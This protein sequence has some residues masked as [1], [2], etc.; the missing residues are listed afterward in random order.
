[1][2]SVAGSRGPAVAP[3]ALAV[4]PLAGDDVSLGDGELGRWQRRNATATASHVVGQLRAAG[5]LDNLR[6]IADGT[7]AAYR[8]R[9]PFLDTDVYKTLEGLAYILA[10][11]D[12]APELRSFFE[13]AVELIVRAQAADGY[14][15]SAFQNPG[16]G[17][18]PWSDLTWGHELYNLGHLIQAAIAAR[19]QLG[20][21]RLLDV[22]V[23][24]ADLA[25][26]RFGP[27]GQSAI[28]GH[29]EV[30]MA[31]VELGR[32]TG[33]PRYLELARLFVDRRGHRSIPASIFEHDYFQDEL[34]LTR[35]PSV[36]GHAVRMGYLAAGAAYVALESGDDLLFAA[37][38]RL[39]DDMSATK[40]H[41]SG[42]LG[43]RHADES[44]GDRYELPADRAYSETCA[45]IAVMQW[46]WRMLLGTGDTR[47]ADLYERVLYNAY[48]VG[49]SEEGTAFF[50]DN[51]LQRR[52][53]HRVPRDGRPLREPWFVCPCCPPNVLRW[54]AQLHE[55]LAVTQGDTLRLVG[56]T[57]GR[58]STGGVRLDIDT[59]YP[60]GSRVAIR[61]LGVDTDASIRRLALRV[62]SWADGM[63]LTV[64][65]STRRAE[66]GGWAE[67][68]GPVR[69]G[70]VIVAEF[71]MP[72]RGHVAHP[73]VD[74]VRGGLAV[75]RGPLLYCVEGAD[76]DASASDADLDDV[77]IAPDSLA[78]AELSALEP[79]G[80]LATAHVAITVPVL[81]V[82]EPTAELYPRWPTPA[83]PPGTPARAVL[84]PYHL[85]GNRRPD[86]MRVWLRTG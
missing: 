75:Q 33:D 5:N 23:R 42:G 62:P 34:P 86:G 73:H 45:A 18:A 35:M 1:M 55:H 78:S 82:P 21:D 37:L 84:R 60:W 26:A 69:E 52:A 51:P 2:T 40:L 11:S 54:T 7:G 70:H 65:G 20:D 28:C 24:F 53:D 59:A 63:T 48:A 43:S 41:I 83:A 77:L 64:D 61:V 6:T 76:I 22:A 16:Y 29:P 13:E 80:G 15:N 67:V 50:Y 68:P 9:Y 44:I 58:I 12:A 85:W 56:Y 47:Y 3:R 17:R 71:D 19:R 57:S 31:L 72:V 27:T 46:S 81:I 32:E 79:S 8:G 14:L 74:A 49:L 4:R 66:A 30:E 25:W 10:G 39:W 38:T 36:H